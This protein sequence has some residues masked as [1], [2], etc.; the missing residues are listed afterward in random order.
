MEDYLVRALTTNKEIRALA[1]R[2]TG[3]VNQAQRAHQTTPVA[4]A[5]LGRALSGALLMG[6]MIKSGDEVGLRIVGDGPLKRIIVEANYYG[7]T[8]GYVGNPQ[9]DL[10][11]NEQ[12]KLDV[13]RAIGKGQLFVTKR[14][15]RE[16]P[17]EG[18]VP[19]VSGE[20]GDDLTYYFTQSEQTPSA[21]GLGVLVDTDLS[22]KAAG[23][24]VIQL[25]PGATEETISRLE[26]NLEGIK[27]VSRLIEEGLS[28][29]ELLEKL[30]AGFDFRILAKREVIFKCK[31]NRERTKE[32][33]ISLSPKELQEILEEEYKIEIKCHFCGETYHFN[34]EEVEEVLQGEDG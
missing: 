16:E 24:F 32:L 9:P 3:V 13:A 23:G 30:L 4:T 14:I 5:A 17:Y 21:V 2:S 31:C 10:M 11:I 12:G 6:A 29:E 8:R 27:S 28:P 7:E 33:L 22:V 25:L 20:I 18:S 34:R 19:L 15:G 1:V 26:D